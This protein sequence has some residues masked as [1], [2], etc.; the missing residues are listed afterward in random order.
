ML[1]T[2]NNRR[3]FILST[4]HVHNSSPK[5]TRQFVGIVLQLLVHSFVLLF[6]RPI[7]NDSLNLQNLF[8]CC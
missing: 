1:F 2:E 3:W 8:S 6:C 7:C 4:K 5:Y